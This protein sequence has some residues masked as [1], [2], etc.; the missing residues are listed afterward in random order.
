MTEEAIRTTG[1]TPKRV[2]ADMGYKSEK[3]LARLEELGVEGHVAMGKGESGEA[4]HKTAGAAT[5]RMARRR[6]GARSQKIYRRRKVIAEPP[7]GWIKSVM[8]FR[9]MSMRGLRKAQ[10]E[11]SLVC[12]A[13][14]LKRLAPRI[15]WQ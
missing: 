1:K 9:G 15:A 7:F 4:Q 5:A 11:W 3:G 10:G 8:G 2:L 14:N 12:L 6:A 13:L